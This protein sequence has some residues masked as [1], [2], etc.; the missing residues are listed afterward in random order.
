[1]PLFMSP[2]GLCVKKHCGDYQGRNK[3]KGR[4]WRQVQGKR[5]ETGTR[6]ER[7]DRFKGREGR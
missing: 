6:D 1:M 7:G 4:E 3:Y 5:G 2:W